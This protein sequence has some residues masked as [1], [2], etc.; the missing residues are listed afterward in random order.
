MSIYKRII[1]MLMVIVFALSSSSLMVIAEDNRPSKDGQT[2]IK[3]S[4]NTDQFDWETFWK[5]IRMFAKGWFYYYTPYDEFMQAGI[6]EFGD[7]RNTGSNSTTDSSIANNTNGAINQITSTNGGHVSN[8]YN[9]NYASTVVYSNAPDYALERTQDMNKQLLQRQITQFNR[10]INN[11]RTQIDNQRI[12]INN[13]NEQIDNQ[14]E[15]IVNQLIM[16]FDMFYNTWGPEVTEQLFLDPTLFNKSIVDTMDANPSLPMARLGELL[17]VKFLNLENI[18]NLKD[19]NRINEQNRESRKVL[20][21][22]VKIALQAT[23]SLWDQHVADTDTLQQLQELAYT[24]EGRNQLIQST[25]M[26]LAF[27]GGESLKLRQQLMIQSNMTGVSLEAGRTEQEAVQSSYEKG[28]SDLDDQFGQEYKFIH[29]TRASTMK[30]NFNGT[31]LYPI[32]R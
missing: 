19:I 8:E 7:P 17:E 26:L 11:Q 6:E 28:V 3:S 1:C 23:G 10:M 18:S 14:H 30:E 16:I 20:M 31:A 5:G 22:T 29:L 9:E 25:N 12:Q 24:A 27:L 13:Q 4:S 2:E 32:F 15:Q 21:D